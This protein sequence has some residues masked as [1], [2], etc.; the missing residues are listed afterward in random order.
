MAP[1]ELRA[2][3]LPDYLKQ[4]RESESDSND[5]ESHGEAQAYREAAAVLVSITDPD[6]L[7]REPATPRPR[8]A[9]AVVGRRPG[10]RYRAE[11]PAH[12]GC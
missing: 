6:T 12:R 1:E 3:E 4:T 5:V 11:S 7:H 10:V 2:A 9:R 8:G